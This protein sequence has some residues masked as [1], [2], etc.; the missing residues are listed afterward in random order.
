MVKNKMALGIKVGM[1]GAICPFH[2][3]SLWK[4]SLVRGDFGRDLQDIS[5]YH[6]AIKGTGLE[7]CAWCIQSTPGSHLAEWSEDRRMVGDEVAEARQ[8]R[9][10]LLL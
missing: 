1:R 4:T 8:H 3:M 7:K 9:L 6:E 5:D 10:W 2:I